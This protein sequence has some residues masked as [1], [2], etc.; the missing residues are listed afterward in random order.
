LSLWADHVSVPSVT[1]A[2]Q[3]DEAVHAT[4]VTARALVG[5]VAGAHVEPALVVVT[6]TPLPGSDAPFDPTAMH[7]VTVGQETPL[8]CGVL[9]PATCW[10]LHDTPALVVATITVV[11]TAAGAGLGP[12]TPTAQQRRALAQDT[13]LS[14]P[15]PTGAGCP[16]M[17]GV[18]L[19]SPRTRGAGGVPECPV[20]AQ[21]DPATATAVSRRVKPPL[22][23]WT[24]RCRGT[25]RGG[26][27]GRE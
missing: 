1:M 2:V 9:P 4:L 27:E 8:S 19:G 25:E 17:S 7:L 15:V 13:A 6:T 5:D 20:S 3:L 18:P 14:S 16:S 23:R 26:T 10:A 22:G 12:A 24:R 21:L 11:P